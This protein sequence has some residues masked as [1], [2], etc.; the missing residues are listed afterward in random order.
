MSIPVALETVSPDDGPGPAVLG[1]TQWQQIGR[2]FRANRPAVTAL[3]VIIVLVLVAVCAPLISAAVGHGP[4]QL[5]PGKL[6]AELGLPTG[7]SRQFL[8]GIDANGRDVFVR[9]VYGLRTSLIVSLLSA[10]IAT[11]VGVTVGM[12]A[13]YFGGW[14]DTLISRS[15]DIFLALPVILFAISIS[16][17]CSITARGC[18]AGTVQPGIGLVVGILALFTW[19]YIAR[20]V[21]GQT[22]AL[23]H[24]DFVSAARGFGAPH[25]KVM[26]GEILPNLTAQVIV[27]MTL[28][29]PSNILFE[30]SLS[31]LGVGVPQTTPSLGR[32]ISDATNGNLFTYAW[33]MMLFPGI[34][35]L[36]ITF[37][38]NVLGDGIRD[39]I[40]GGS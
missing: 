39:S 5:F 15:A 1:R 30:A 14:L 25:L 38:F 6:S 26:F 31:F 20:L 18:L 13:G 32:M 10:A 21:R 28:I 4:N 2:A 23:R 27:Y 36:L 24:L 9:C 3:V 22:L 29:I 17:V 8:F 11:V 37:S 40:T 7:P 35:L 34:L 19:P 16:S 33:W 12:A